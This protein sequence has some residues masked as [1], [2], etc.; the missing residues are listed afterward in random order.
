LFEIAQKLISIRAAEIPQAHF[1][2]FYEDT[3]RDFVYV[4]GASPEITRQT[5]SNDFPILANKDTPRFLFSPNAAIYN[6]QQ[7]FII[8]GHK[9]KPDRLYPKCTTKQMSVILRG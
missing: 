3:L 1:P 7:F 9:V 4:F 5:T 8:I 6:G 2:Q